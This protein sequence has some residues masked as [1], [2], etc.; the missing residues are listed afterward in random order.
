MLPRAFKNNLLMETGKND[1]IVVRLDSVSEQDPNEGGSRRNQNRLRRKSMDWQGLDWQTRIAVFFIACGAAI[2]GISIVYL[3]GLFRATPLIAE[4][5]QGYVLRLLKIN[6]LL[7]FFFLAGYV[8]VAMS[9]LF[10]QVSLG[11]FWVSLI[12]LLGAVFVFLGIAL[13]AR[14]ISEIQQ[15]IQGLLPI[16]MECKKIRTTGGD[17]SEQTSWKEIESYISQRTDAKFSHGI[18]P[19][20]LAKARQRRK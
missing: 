14:M 10:G 16:C 6:R 17:S 12:F 19:Q 9:V 5:S 3:R 20:C 1:C 13:H 18:C 4:R 7:M 8:V 15:T 11:M 2:I